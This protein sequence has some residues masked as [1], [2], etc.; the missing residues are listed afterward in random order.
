MTIMEA[1]LGATTEPRMTQIG[2]PMSLPLTCPPMMSENGMKTSGKSQNS[3]GL[4]LPDEA[5]DK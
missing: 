4:S 5:K 2:A 1:D 3:T